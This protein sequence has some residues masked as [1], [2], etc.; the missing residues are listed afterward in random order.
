MRIE[1]LDVVLR[2]RSHWQA[3]E[4]GTALV[5]RRARVVWGTW[6]MASLP[7]LVLVNALALWRDTGFFAAALVMW[8]C[9]PLFERAVLYVLSR[10]VFGEPVGVTQAVGAQ[11]R[12]TTQGFWGYLGWRR[13]SLLRSVCLPVNLLEGAPPAQRAQR[14][15]AVLAGV[16]G[17]VLV[18]ALLC[19]VFE[20]VLLTGALTA[21]FLFMPLELLSDSWRAAWELVSE[22]TPGWA[23]AALNVL[24]WLAA[25]VIGPFHVGAG[26]GL[27]LN[28]RTQMEA[29]D[30]ELGL[31]RLRARLLQQSGP[32]LALLLGVATATPLLLPLPLAA[33]EQQQEQ[34]TAEPVTQAR[35]ADDAGQTAA[36]IFGDTAVDTAGFRQAV[37]RG[38]E[39]PLQRPTRTVTR[40]VPREQATEDEPTASD[41]PL[42]AQLQP[43]FAALAA[44]IAMGAEWGLWLLLGVLLLVLAWTARRW[45]PW[46]RWGR[47]AARSAPP[48]LRE[49]SIELPA[50]LPPDVATRARALWAGG[51]PRQALALLYRASVR[52][53]QERTTLALPPGTTEAQA[54]RASRRMPEAR[55]REVF[56]TMVRVWQYAAYGNQLPTEDAFLQLAE[57][58]QAQYRWQA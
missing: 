2:E 17:P 1:Q 49:D 10:D 24:Y 11:W 5:R 16:L 35:D 55:D 12:W 56:A 7:V 25:S 38:F 39:D 31:R 29:W 22:D 18:L 8:W 46:L 44:L 26:F 50:T 32:L 42:A 36:E 9:K 21:V 41:N 53:V 4:L 34:A 45:M 51:Q 14:R 43:L 40:W 19:L 37:Q 28:R 15:R 58:L 48:A 23:K 33:Q 27:Y 47:K 54:L 3:M 20:L 6:L 52:T 57:A 30:V 13:P